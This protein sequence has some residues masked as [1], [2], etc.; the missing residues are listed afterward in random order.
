MEVVLGSVGHWED[1]WGILSINRIKGHLNSICLQSPLA[2]SL[3]KLPWLG[4]QDG[5]VIEW[6]RPADRWH[7]PALEL[8]R[9]RKWQFA[10]LKPLPGELANRLDMD[11][12]LAAMMR[13]LGTPR[14]DPETKSP[15]T[16]LLDVLAD[17]VARGDV[18]HW[19]VFLGQVRSAW[20]G[21]EPTVGSPFP[22]RLLVQR[23]SSRLTAESP[24]EYGP[25][26]LA[27]S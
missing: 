26:Y 11:S 7:V 22:N 17:A 2:R 20:R 27:D 8:A 25:A 5:D 4:L 14:F 15:S 21:F 6:S 16:Q 10:H 3:S 1:G 9:G 19:D 18:P 24:D 13:L 23:G 12:R